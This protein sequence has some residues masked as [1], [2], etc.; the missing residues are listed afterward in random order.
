MKTT[1]LGPLIV[2]EL[3][4]GAMYFGTRVSEPTGFGLLDRYI[5][6][7]GN[8]IDT[9]NNYAFWPEGGRSGISEE[10][11]GRWLKRSGKRNDLVIATKVGARPN[12]PGALLDDI[13]GLGREVII[14]NA[15]ESLKRLGTDRIDLYYAHIDDR[16]TPLEE[17]L[18][19]FDTLVRSGK[20]RAIACSNYTTWRIE[21]ARRISRAGNLAEY[22][23]VQQRH[24]FLKPHAHAKFDI[25]LTAKRG[26][27]GYA[28]GTSPELLDYAKQHPAFR[29]VAYSPLLEGGYAKRDKINENY[30]SADNDARL[31]VL[32]VMARE[33]GGTPGQIVLAWMLKSGIIPLMSAS[34]QSQLDENLGAASL[35]LT[36][37]QMSR[38]D[39]SYGGLL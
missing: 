9:S 21:A 5:A 34:S 19:A 11:L 31:A 16:I 2:S 33:T 30:R 8:F 14:V 35:E 10:V 3:A 20:V 28:A 13:Q 32:D 12:R 4:Y 39:E 7:G 23:A 25:A 24:T 17:T 27:P 37:E 18:A 26:A 29:I 15:E 22:V 38:L 36:A 6:A 1:Q